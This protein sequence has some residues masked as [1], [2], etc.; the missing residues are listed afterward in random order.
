MTATRA[1]LIAA[2]GVTLN[3]A[4]QLWYLRIAENFV[5][6]FLSIAAAGLG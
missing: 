4:S 5:F 2:M 6:A 3:T 1:S